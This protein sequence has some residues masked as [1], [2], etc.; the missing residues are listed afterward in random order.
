MKKRLIAIMCC[1]A[2]ALSCV[3]IAGC[4]GSGGGSDVDLSDSAYVGTWKATKATFQ[5]EEVAAEEVF[6]SG[7]LIL[8]LNADGTAELSEGTDKSTGNWSEADG[9]VKVKGDDINMTFKDTDGVLEG[10]V[11]GMHIFFEKQA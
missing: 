10:E 2:L 4:G 8:L 1:V 5:G 6:T 7:D 9:G 11:I 3:A